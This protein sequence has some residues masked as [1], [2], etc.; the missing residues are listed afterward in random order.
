[1][2]TYTIIKIDGKEYSYRIYG[3]RYGK[4]LEMF[5]G[6]D[7]IHGKSVT[8]TLNGHEQDKLHEAAKVLEN[9]NNIPF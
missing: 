2:K 6:D 7:I 5:E 3:N 9:S 8:M 4:T 1:M